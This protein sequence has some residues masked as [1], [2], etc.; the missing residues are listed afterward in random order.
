MQ[1]IQHK[2]SYHYAIE[3]GGVS[4]D[5]MKWIALNISYLKKTKEI[6]DFGTG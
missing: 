2:N 5:K 1:L 3:E 6:S 4:Q